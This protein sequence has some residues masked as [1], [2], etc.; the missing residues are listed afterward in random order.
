M[1]KQPNP[2]LSSAQNTVVP[3]WWLL[4]PVGTS[5]SLLESLGVLEDI[6]PLSLLPLLWHQWVSHFWMIAETRKPDLDC[7]G[8]AEV[9]DMPTEFTAVFI[10]LPGLIPGPLPVFHPPWK[11]HTAT[12]QCH[13]LAQHWRFLLSGCHKSALWHICNTCVQ[14]YP[15]TFWPSSLNRKVLNVKCSEAFPITVQSKNVRKSNFWVFCLILDFSSK[16]NW[17]THFFNV[18]NQGSALKVKDIWRSIPCHHL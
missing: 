9:Q 8:Q 4:Y 15:H 13:L 16:R 5:W 10:P 17:I 11:S 1:N 6:Y 14:W 3:K 7:S 12:Q 18:I 2:I